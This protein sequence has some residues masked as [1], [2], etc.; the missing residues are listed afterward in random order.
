MYMNKLTDR[1]RK[2]L[3][4]AGELA[5]IWGSEFVLTEHL[6]YALAED[7]AS[8]AA[9]VLRKMGRGSGPEAILKELNQK[10]PPPPDTKTLT[11]GVRPSLH[12]PR[13]KQVLDLSVEESYNAG[14]VT[15]DTG[16][17]LLALKAESGGEAC[18]II[19]KLLGQHVVFVALQNQVIM[20]GK[21]MRGMAP[22]M[23]V[24]DSDKPHTVDIKV[25]LYAEAEKPNGHYFVISKTRYYH[26]STVEASNIQEVDADQVAAMLAS[27]SK[28]SVY[29]VEILRK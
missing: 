9:I 27:V 17:L 19:G 5:G 1:S 18:R 29:K 15:I 8:I 11:V 14:A 10:A 6:L 7:E 26:H 25:H 3:V 22:E 21:L 23:E 4:R 24:P 20:T 12:S 2:A 13:L 16:H 28:T